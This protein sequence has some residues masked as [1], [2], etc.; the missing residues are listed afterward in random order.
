[1]N[2]IIITIIVSFLLA[3]ILGVLLGFFKKVFNVPVDEKV[4]KV[5][6][7]LPGANCGACGFPGCDGFAAAVASG[8]APVDGCAAGGASTAEKVGNVLGKTVE[9]ETKVVVLACQGSKEL[10]KARGFYTGLKNCAAA[11]QAVNGTKMCQYGCIGFGDC[12]AVC[13]FDALHMGE[14]GLPQVDYSKCTGCGMCVKECPQHLLSKVPVSRKGAVALCSNH[15]EN[16]PSVIKNC[17]IGCIKCGKCERNCPEKC[18]KL[19]NGIPQIDYDKCTS[20]GTC[21]EGCPTKVLKLVETVI[22]K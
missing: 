20:C 14:N 2:T 9:T 15:T 21:I 7:V 10:A 4:A 22:N 17:K 3:L 18:L 16:K 6:E 5:R 11:H 1:M 19:V 12:V 8:E 13:Q